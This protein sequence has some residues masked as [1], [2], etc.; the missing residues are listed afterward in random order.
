MSQAQR[1]RAVTRRYPEQPGR[2]A[3]EAFDMWP[4]FAWRCPVCGWP[5]DSASAPV[6]PCCEIPAAGGPASTPNLAPKGIR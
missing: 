4:R 3:D 6:H 5:I 1:R 2:I